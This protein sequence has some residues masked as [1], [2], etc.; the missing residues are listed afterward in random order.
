[1]RRLKTISLSVAMLLIVV[2]AGSAWGEDAQ[3]SAEGKNLPVAYQLGVNGYLRQE[4]SRNFAIGDAV[5]A[6]GHDEGRFV[7]RLQPYAVWNPA[8]SVGIRIEGQGYGIR[9]GYHQDDS[10]F[11]LYQ[12]Y[13]DLSL[14]GSELLSLRAGR[15]EFN[16]GSGFILSND[17]FNDGLTFDSLRLRVKP[18]KEVTIDLLGG[19]YVRRFADDRK[20][21]LAGVYAGY[22]PNDDSNVE[23]YSFYD[24][25]L[26]GRVN[27]DR[28]YVWGARMTS[29]L[30]PVAVE[31]EPVYESGR[32]TSQALG[33]TDDIRAYGGHVDL[34]ME[35]Q[36]RGLKN[37]I[38]LGYALGSGSQEAADG[39]RFNKEFKTPNSNA[40]FSELLSVVGDLSGL[41][42]GSSHASG[43]E[44]YTLSFGTDLPA[45]LNLTFCNH[46][47]RAQDVP[48][49]FSKDI[50]IETTSYLTWTP[51]DN[52]SL[53]LAYTHLFSGGFFRDATGTDRG[54]DIAFLQ[55]QFD[56]S[57]KKTK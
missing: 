19:R 47:F 45:N 11:A 49:G 30:G 50:G 18:A 25:G 39:I 20:G 43:I 27:G 57:Y 46:Y 5:Y 37:K 51:M 53:M 17:P 10:R 14:P 22:A 52:L 44:S 56:L 21:V 2:A 42:A 32:L 55:A 31:V 24:T 35:G 36:W 40:S 54:V 12:G 48:S 26:E 33:T 3:P 41:D 4:L 7:Y 1:M 29:K 16:Y 6:P 13:A 38:S 28:L 8:D 15:Q 9:G 34:G 23:L